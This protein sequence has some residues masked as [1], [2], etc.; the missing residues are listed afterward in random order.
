MS[1]NTDTMNTQQQTTQTPAET[2]GRMFSQDEVNRIVS[3]RLARER[4]KLADGSEYKAKYEAVKQELEGIKAAQ[5]HQQKEA[6]Y[7]D[8]LAKANISEK[9]V[10]TVM[11]EST[12]EIDALQLDESGAVVGA[13]KLVKDI[14]TEWADF[15][16]HT[17]VRGADT[18]NPPANCGGSGDPIANAF[19]PKI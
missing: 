10:A 2:G 9:R 17:V 6:A 12:A 15:V 13:D 16:V 18:C 3:D 14:Q 8:L 5:T 19:K 4:E 11:K 1:E 7:R